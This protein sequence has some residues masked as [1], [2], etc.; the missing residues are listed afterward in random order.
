MISSNLVD[1]IKTDFSYLSA[2][3]PAIAE[4]KKYGRIKSAPATLAI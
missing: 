4:N 1:F 2:I 3:C